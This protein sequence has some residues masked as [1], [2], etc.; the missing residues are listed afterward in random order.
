M[1]KILKTHYNITA[2]RLPKSFDEMKIAVLSD[3][4]DNQYGID[5]EKLYEMIDMEK[6]D[7]IIFAGDLITRYP[8]SDS[9]QVFAFVKR[10]SLKYPIYFANG[11]HETRVG[12]E[13]D[14][15]GNRYEEIMKELKSYG[16][17]VLNNDVAMIIKGNDYINIFGLEIGRDYFRHFYDSRR[18][19]ADCAYVTELLGKRPEGFNIL[20]AHNPTYFDA[21]SEWGAD[22]IF[23]GHL[24]GGIMRLPFVGGLIN[25]DY[26]LFPKYSKGLFKRKHSQMIVSAG[27]GAHTIKMRINNPTELVFVTLHNK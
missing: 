3:L 10:L 21:Y 8:D 4:H 27:L 1:K 9:T 11:N 23:G 12:L 18:K 16:V 5:I 15:F 7:I 22:L 24:H 14:S 17:T 20:I 26:S 19:K 6:P 25:P 2:D 13:R